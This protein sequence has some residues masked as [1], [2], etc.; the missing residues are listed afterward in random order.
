MSHEAS[1]YA[2]PAVSVELPFKGSKSGDQRYLSEED[3]AR[4]YSDEC[5]IC[6]YTLG[7]DKQYPTRRCSACRNIFHPRC[8]SEWYRGSNTRRCPLCKYDLSE[9]PSAHRIY[10]GAEGIREVEN[11]QRATASAPSFFPNADD[12]KMLRQERR[13]WAA[14]RHDAT[15]QDK[16][17]RARVDRGDLEPEPR[18]NYEDV[19]RDEH[20]SLY[21]PEYFRQTN[22]GREHPG[23]ED[24]ES[25]MSLETTGPTLPP[26]SHVASQQSQPRRSNVMNLLRADPTPRR[27]G[28]KQE[29]Q[30]L[31]STE[32]R[33]AKAREY[34]V[35]PGEEARNEKLEYIKRQHA[36]SKGSD[37]FARWYSRNSSVGPLFGEASRSTERASGYRATGGGR[38]RLLHDETDRRPSAHGGTYVGEE[39]REARVAEDRSVRS[40]VS[41]WQ[42][43]MPVVH[44]TISRDNTVNAESQERALLRRVL[45]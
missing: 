41:E 38:R 26:S 19:I 21:D 33:T 5:G 43:A 42:S 11:A 8:L 4:A 24:R 10:M 14:P 31:S 39:S 36:T 30:T 20:P 37:P 16:R 22:S 7:V 1:P 25:T 17:I 23:R 15:R 18:S 9:R 45:I 13:R 3:D 6:Y 34:P 12:E 40:R 35:V 44:S 32:F 27:R 28:R 29:D 2:K